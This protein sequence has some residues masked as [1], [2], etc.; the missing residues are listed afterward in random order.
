MVAGDGERPRKKKIQSQGSATALFVLA[1]G[2]RPTG[3]KEKGF[4]CS[5]QM[6]KIAPP[7]FLC[8]RDS[9]L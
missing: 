9:Y 1:S 8:V 3:L 5:F 7:H 6:C 4:L 2:G